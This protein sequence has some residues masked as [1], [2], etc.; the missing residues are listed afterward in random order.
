MFP[1]RNLDHLIELTHLLILNLDQSLII[2][3]L[4]D[5]QHFNFNFLNFKSL[6]FYIIHHFHQLRYPLIHR[7]NRIDQFFLFYYNLSFAFT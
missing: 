1:P 2:V 4:K 5:I 6:T 3:I 7:Q